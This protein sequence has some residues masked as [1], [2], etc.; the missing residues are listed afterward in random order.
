MKGS[1]VYVGENGEVLSEIHQQYWSLS[2]HWTVQRWG[3]QL[4]TTSSCLFSDSARWNIKLTK[5]APSDVTKG[6]QFSMIHLPHISWR[7]SKSEYPASLKPVVTTPPARCWFRPLGRRCFHQQSTCCSRS[8]DWGAALSP[9]NTGLNISP[10]AAKHW[11][12]K[13]KR[14]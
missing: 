2:C 9:V 8:R 10:E 14:K 3:N 13:R 4:F 12:K 1:F 11:V 7:I 6:M 5:S